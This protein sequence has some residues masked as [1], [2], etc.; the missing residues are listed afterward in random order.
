MCVCLCVFVFVFAFVCVF[1]VAPAS[2]GVCASWGKTGGSATYSTAS[3]SP[4]NG[5]R[6]RVRDPSRKV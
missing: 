1:V 4:A 6:E 3:P 5:E 2:E